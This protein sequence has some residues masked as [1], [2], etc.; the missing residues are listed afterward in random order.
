AFV[1]ILLIPTQV[2][3]IDFDISE[4]RIDVELNEDGTANVT[5]QFTYQFDDDFNGI[6]R[7]LIAKEGTSIENFS[8]AENGTS[9]TVERED[10][11]YR[12]YRSGQGG[13]TVEIDLSY[14][15][16]NAV[17][18]FEDGAQFYWA[19]F[20]QSNESEYGDMTIFVTPPAPAEDTVALGYEEA[21]ET[22]RLTDDGAVIFELG[23]VPDG[24][25]AN[26]RAIFEPDLF[27]DAAA[28]NGTV[29]D[30]LAEEREQ[31]EDEAALFARNQ[32]IAGNIGVPTI[33]I[34]GALLL[35]GILMAWMRAFQRKRQIRNQPYE[36]FVPKESMSIPALLHFTNSPVLS[37]NVISAAIL[38]LMRK[39]N[40]RQ[41]AEDHFE[42]INRETEHSHEDA[43]IRLLFD[44][45]GG[46][47]EFKLEQ[48]QEFTE[49]E[50][51]HETYNDALTEWNGGITAEV[52]AQGFYEK[53]PVLRWTAGAMSL[54]FIALAVYTATYDFFLWMVVSI[55]MATIALGFA[56]GYSPITFEGHEIRQNWQKLKASMENL[57]EE[58]WARLTI[59]E[60][61]RAYAY[62]LGSDPKTAERKAAVFTSAESV[63]DG[64]SF[65]MNPVFMTAVFVTASTT[66]STSASASGGMA[67]TGAGVGG[68]G[69]GSGAF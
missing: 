45:I 53:H 20:D 30:D 54:L 7:S 60:K 12:I 67:G 4:V 37:P 10:G 40:I 24:E 21:F 28:L 52:K 69:G 57:P 8:A 34:I 38:E 2:H 65:I 6:T 33:A 39:G 11:F 26:I 36:F 31:L 29:R 27:P 56:I 23:F 41:L 15:I 48:V 66:T 46:G 59:D 9:L 49:N 22:E 43:L 50:D 18:K 47:R 64:S 14:E 63:A 62:L 68:G 61:Q 16:I 32:Q 13:D 35:I 51:H 58:Q 1:L 44:R 19:F 25:N 42:L 3:A 5:E 17:E 55:A